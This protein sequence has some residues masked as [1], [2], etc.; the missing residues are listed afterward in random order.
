MEWNR[1]GKTSNVE[2]RKRELREDKKQRRERR[3]KLKE[4]LPGMGREL[5]SEG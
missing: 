2:A 4:L 5:N 1:K 3:E